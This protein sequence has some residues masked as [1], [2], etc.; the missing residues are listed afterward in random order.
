MWGVLAGKGPP[1]SGPVLA[2]PA[3][4]AGQHAEQPAG[5]QRPPGPLGRQQRTARQS[6]QCMGLPFPHAQPKLAGHAWDQA[7]QPAGTTLAFPSHHH[8][9]MGCCTEH[10]YD[11]WLVASEGCPGDAESTQQHFW[12]SKWSAHATN[13]LWLAAADAASPAAV[14][15]SRG[16][17]HSLSHSSS[18]TLHRTCS[19]GAITNVRAAGEI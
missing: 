16:E 11:L 13:E 4:A 8:L 14:L 9:I 1:A 17:H 10:T 2:G 15:A 3:A 6:S 12:S 7:K 18:S 19:L 5:W